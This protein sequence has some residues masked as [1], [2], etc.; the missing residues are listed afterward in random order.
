MV[1]FKVLMTF[2]YKT[3]ILNL[4]KNHSII[5]RNKDESNLL[6]N[7]KLIFYWFV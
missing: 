6:S 2:K 4:K 3:C 1:L 7:F 5:E